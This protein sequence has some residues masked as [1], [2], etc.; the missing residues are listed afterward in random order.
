MSYDEKADEFY[1]RIDD[2]TKT[3]AIIFEIDDIDEMCFYIREGTMDHIDD[4]DGLETYLKGLALILPGDSLLL[5]E[6][7]IY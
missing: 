5:C 2:G 1:A 6:K 4:V 7:M 3:G